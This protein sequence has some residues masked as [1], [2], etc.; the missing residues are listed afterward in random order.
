MTPRWRRW[1]A[2]F[3]ALARRV[4][5]RRLLSRCCGTSG[6]TSKGGRHELAKA[7]IE[8]PLRA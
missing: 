8:R 4:P 5:E 1:A 7:G 6:I 3:A 2:T